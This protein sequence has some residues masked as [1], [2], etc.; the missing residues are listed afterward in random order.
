MAGR[1]AALNMHE[2]YKAPRARAG[3]A[4]F[5]HPQHEDSRFGLSSSRR[6]RDLVLKC[7]ALD[8]ASAY[9]ERPTQ[10]KSRLLFV[11]W[12]VAAAGQP[13]GSPD[14][15]RGCSRLSPNATRAVDGGHLVAGATSRRGIS[16]ST[17]C[18]SVAPR[19]PALAVGGGAFPFYNLPE[20]VAWRGVA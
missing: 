4:P 1:S 5:E 10:I 14:P 15:S 7:D 16:A 18:P 20:G 9:H 3:R 8:P 17:S 12:R 11:R 19:H 6:R 13:G 2:P